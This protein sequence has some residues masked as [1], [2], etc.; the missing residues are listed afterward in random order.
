MPGGLLTEGSSSL[1]GSVNSKHT[2]PFSVPFEYWYLQ[3][4]ESCALSPAQLVLYI[5]T[6]MTFVIMC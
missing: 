6:K 5:S 3:C 1:I 4:Y 2:L